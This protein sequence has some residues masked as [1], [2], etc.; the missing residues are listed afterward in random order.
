[1]P[2]RWVPAYCALP[3]AHCEP[4]SD[5]QLGHRFPRGFFGFELFLWWDEDIPAEPKLL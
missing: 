1:E 2:L 5:I 4:A 3:A